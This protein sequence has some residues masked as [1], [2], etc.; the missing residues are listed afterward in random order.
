MEFSASRVVGKM[1]VS[2]MDEAQF[3]MSAENSPKPRVLV[4]SFAYYPMVGGLPQQARLLN[5]ALQDHGVAVTLVTVWIDGCPKVDLLDNVP[6]YRLWTFLGEP[7]AGYRSRIYPWL[8]PLTAFLISHQ[9]D[10]DVIHVHQASYP[11]AVCVVMGKILGKPT[12]IRIT[13][14]GDS[15]N[16]ATLKRLWWLGLPVRLII[17]HTNRFVSL[18]DDI[19]KELL[20]EGISQEKIIYIQNGVD[21]DFFS[22]A[23]PQTDLRGRIVLGVGRFSEEKG[24]DILVTAWAKVVRK[25]PDARLILVGEGQDL[26][27]LKALVKR[28]GIDASISFEGNHDNVYNYLNQADIYVLPSRNEGM[29]NSLLEAMS[30]GRACIV[31]DIPANWSVVTPDVDGLMFRRDNSDDLADRIVQ[32]LQDP[33]L[34]RKMGEA[35]RKKIVDKFS[36]AAVAKKYVQ[37]YLE[38]TYNKRGSSL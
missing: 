35:A 20:E 6:V 9:N 25:E 7:S 10:Y 28:L 24:F 5:R 3:T 2:E 13:G 14:S 18:S 38:L 12:V 30:M 15:G 27:I 37:L 23:L 36:I 26:P 8:L 34:G 11:A 4:V 17:R 1:I 19:T 16:I 33:D 32:L 22:P 21:V 31:S 29:S